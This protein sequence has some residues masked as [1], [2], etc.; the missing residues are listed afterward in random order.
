MGGTYEI[1]VLQEII[2]LLICLKLFPSFMEPKWL[3]SGGE[4]VE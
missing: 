1:Y 3:W 4:A 2:P